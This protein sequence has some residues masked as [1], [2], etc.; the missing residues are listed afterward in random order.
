MCC[1]VPFLNKECLVCLFHKLATLSE[2][3]ASLA[4][5][6]ERETPHKR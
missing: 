2:R 6:G 4:V 3:G 5:Q 1:R